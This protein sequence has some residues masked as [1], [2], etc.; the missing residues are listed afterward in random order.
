LIQ[1]NNGA[2]YGTT[3]GGGSHGQGTVF[4]LNEDGSSYGVLRSFGSSIPGGQSPMGLVQGSDGALYGTTSS[5]G[6]KN[7]GTVYRLNDDGSDY[8]VLHDFSGPPN[9]GQ[10]PAGGV[11]EGSD[12]TLYGE[13]WIG[14]SNT[15]G[16]VFK[17]NKD[18]SG[19]RILHSFPDTSVDGFYPSDRLLQGNNQALFGTTWSGGI[20]NG[21]TVFKLNTDGSSYSV[22]YNFG[23]TGVDGSYPHAAVIQGSDGALYGTTTGGGTYTNQNGKTGG[24]V[25]RVNKDGSGYSVLYNF[26]STGGDGRNPQTG[27]TQGS[28]GALY[29]TTFGGGDSGFGTVFK[30]WPPETPDLT[31]VALGPGGSEII[32]AGLSGYRYQVLRST[33]LTNW[34]VLTNIIM[35]AGGAYTNLDTSPPAAA[36]YYRAAWVP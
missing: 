23:S 21:G 34:S 31:S 27:L 14:G 16:T 18:G 5:G 6:A 3:I 10:A 11:I 28:D 24:T 20:N 26:G 8:S 22:L 29:G 2:L 4:K 32:F 12:G 33:D 25:F 9:D 15:V 1:A 7:L 30:I 13:T 17:M 36:A 35:P 19:Y